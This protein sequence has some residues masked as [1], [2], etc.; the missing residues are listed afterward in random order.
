M[1]PLSDKRRSSYTNNKQHPKL[2]TL[3]Y[4]IANTKRP[5]DAPSSVSPVANTKP[6]DTHVCSTPLITDKKPLDTE[7]PGKPT[8][9]SSHIYINGSI[10]EG[11]G[12][13]IRNAVTLA[14]V[15]SHPLTIH[16]IPIRRPG[17]KSLRDAHVAA[18][19]SHAEVN[20]SIVESAKIG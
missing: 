12:Q 14:A 9:R 15:T 5:H 8:A 4:P 19:E 1:S 3:S 20:N 11:G 17:Q 13:V 2:A 18:I 7:V 16:L 10:Y 6:L